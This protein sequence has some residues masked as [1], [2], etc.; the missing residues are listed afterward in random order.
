MTSQIHYRPLHMRDLA[1]V[2]ALEAQVFEPQHRR[3]YLK[4]RELMAIPSIKGFNLST[5]AFQDGRLVAYTLMFPRESSF[6]PGQTVASIFYIAALPGYGRRS[7]LTLIERVIEQAQI[8]GFLAVEANC[9]PLMFR[10]LTRHPARWEERLFR[11]AATAAAGEQM[12]VRFEPIGARE[13]RVHAGWYRALT[14][15][16]RLRRTTLALPRRTLRLACRSVPEGLVPR[17]LLEMTYLDVQSVP[18]PSESAPDDKLHIE[19]REHRVYEH[20]P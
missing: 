17:R 18:E 19:P 10:I 8:C 9:S 15:L 5:G 16:E 3:G 12:R 13:E 1:E 6:V 2:A 7:L 14:Q 20:E 11:I 4:L